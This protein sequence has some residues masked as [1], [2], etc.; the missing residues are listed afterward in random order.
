MDEK[1]GVFIRSIN[2]GAKKAVLVAHGSIQGTTSECLKNP[3]VV[4]D[5]LELKYYAHHSESVHLDVPKEIITTNYLPCLSPRK[6]PVKEVVE[7]GEP[8]FNYGLS[9]AS[10]VFQLKPTR[11]Y[12]IIGVRGNTDIGNVMKSVKEVKPSIK[13]I[14]TVSCRT[15]YD[16]KG[17]PKKYGQPVTYAD[18]NRVANNSK[19]YGGKGPF[20]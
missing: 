5:D 17:K 3:A 15:E 7:A 12:D 1:D 6:T 11:E 4:P 10:E 13:V 18:M 9:P 8:S 16:W 14:H 2:P 19:I 20:D